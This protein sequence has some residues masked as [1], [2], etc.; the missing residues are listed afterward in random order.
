[1]ISSGLVLFGE[2]VSL[3][4]DQTIHFKLFGSRDDS[5]LSFFRCFFLLSTVTSHLT[6]GTS[7]AFR[8]SGLAR[9]KNHHMISLY[10]SQ[11]IVWKFFFFFLNSKFT[12]DKPNRALN[13]PH[14]AAYPASSPPH[15]Q[16]PWTCPD[17]ELRTE[18]AHRS[19]WPR[20][21]SVQCEAH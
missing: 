18:V 14:P 2:D 4:R 8:L 11:L 12:R 1:M 3:I 9:F 17:Q 21:Q 10:V 19:M 7:F 20:K 5:L 6:S 15:N 16:G 13:H